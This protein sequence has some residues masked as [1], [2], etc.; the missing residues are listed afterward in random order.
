MLTR[1]YV[2]DK[3]M[4]ISNRSPA[5]ANQAMRVLRALWNYAVAEYRYPDDT[6]IFGDNPVNILSEQG[7]W[8][9]I[10]PRNSKIPIDKVGLAWNILQ[11]LNL[12]Q[13]MSL[14]NI[15][16]NFLA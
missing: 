4:E 2:K 5:Q 13:L 9:T 16:L 11:S 10:Q 12:L 1:A 7:L 15:F 8:N 6:T 3:F 14:E